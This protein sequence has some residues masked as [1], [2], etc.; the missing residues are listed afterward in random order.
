MRLAR[1]QDRLAS[2]L[3]GKECSGWVLDEGAEG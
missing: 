1:N 3:S 2:G